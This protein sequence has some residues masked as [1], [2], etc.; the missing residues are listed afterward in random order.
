MI[1]STLRSGC[2]PACAAALAAL[3]TGVFATRVT[4]AT[5]SIV[6]GARLGVLEG[7]PLLAG[8]IVAVIVTWVLDTASR[9][10]YA[11]VRPPTRRSAVG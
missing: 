3:L 9:L 8:Q 11:S 1:C 10:R 5:E 7:G 6:P 4:G 2:A